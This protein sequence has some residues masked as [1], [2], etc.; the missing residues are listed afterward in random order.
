MSALTIAYILLFYGAALVFVIGLFYR[1]FKYATTP[2]PLKIPT[3]PAP[4]NQ[5]GVV[6]RLFWEVVFFRSLFRSAKWIWLFG[7]MFHLALFVIVLRHLRYFTDPVWAPIELIQPFGIYAGFV[8]SVG[9][10]GL[11]VRRFS[12]ARV[13]YVSVISD[14]FML[15]LLLA[16]VVSGL[17]MKYVVHTDIVAF[18][19]FILGIMSFQ[20][21]SLPGTGAGEAPNVALLIHLF[22]VAVLMLIFPFSKLMHAP[23]LFF[24]PTRNQID[25][26]RAE[27]GLRSHESRHVAQWALDS[28]SVGKSGV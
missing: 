17:A 27:R 15:V 1:I 11:W 9:L 20:W 18:K 10:I 26:P 8:M 21:V 14:H 2:A 25:N 19:T 13:R 22:L 12:V 23:G 24:C 6:F 4:L 16:I 28:E 7:W 5:R 3:T